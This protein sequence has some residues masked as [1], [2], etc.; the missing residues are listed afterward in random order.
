MYSLVACIVGVL[1]AVAGITVIVMRHRVH[2]FVQGR[3]EK[4]LRADGLADEE[5]A[6]RTP[7]RWMIMSLG[8]GLLVVSVLFV[9][10]GLS[11]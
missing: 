5:I 9:A 8:V 1:S 11:S 7:G 2:R 3:Y 6:D 10:I 4:M